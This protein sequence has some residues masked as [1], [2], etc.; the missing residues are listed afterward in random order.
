MHF[1]TELV[2]LSWTVTKKKS[3]MLG[4]KLSQSADD[5]VADKWG[6]LPFPNKSRKIVVVWYIET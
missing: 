5:F 4:V 3:E 6:C 1:T 2:V